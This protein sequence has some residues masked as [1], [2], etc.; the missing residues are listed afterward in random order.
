MAWIMLLLVAYLVIALRARTYQ[1][2][3]HLAILLVT[4][5]T[6]GVVF[7]QPVSPK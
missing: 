4:A 2:S 7:L 6:L 3:T 5:V 1:G